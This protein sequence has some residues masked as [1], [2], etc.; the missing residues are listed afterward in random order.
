MTEAISQPDE[1]NP[2]GTEQ[3]IFVRPGRVTGP[4]DGDA[5]RDESRQQ[6]AESIEEPAKIL[7]LNSMIKQ[8]LEE[9]RSAPLDEPSRK[10]LREIHANSVAELEMGLSPELREELNRLT[11]PF[12]EDATPSGAELRIAQAQLVG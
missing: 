5:E 3:R 8:L 11:L 12:S 7:R 4:G 9:V 2:V 1:M 6:G 10:R